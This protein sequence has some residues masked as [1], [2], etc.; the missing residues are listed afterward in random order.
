MKVD[1]SKKDSLAVEN[2]KAVNVNVF[3]TN[4]SNSNDEESNLNETNSVVAFVEKKLDEKL[5]NGI[6][7]FIGEVGCVILFFLILSGLLNSLLK[8][9][10]KFLHKL[11]GLSPKQNKYC[12]YIAHSFNVP[13]RIKLEKKEINE[14]C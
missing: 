12:V 9:L 5:K 1:Y 10:L 3:C 13:Y 2:R 8:T 7:N 11:L 14:D 4:L 6:W